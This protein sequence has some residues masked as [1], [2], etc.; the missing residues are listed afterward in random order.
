MAIAKIND[1]RAL[2]PDELAKRL[3][4]Y[5][6]E[7]LEVGDNPK[8]PRNL[9]RAIARIKTILNEGKN[10]SKKKEA[11]KKQEAKPEK[12]KVK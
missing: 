1:L 11:H 3:E 4:T 5:E 7:M 9:R 8:K 2:A 10:A 6:R 12:K